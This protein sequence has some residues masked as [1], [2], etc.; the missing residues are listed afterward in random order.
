MYGTVI[1]R[2]LS[3]MGDF[4]AGSGDNCN[5]II[6]VIIYPVNKTYC[7]WGCKHSDFEFDGKQIFCIYF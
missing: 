7:S 3:H 2:N 4:T 5:I 6:A 1:A